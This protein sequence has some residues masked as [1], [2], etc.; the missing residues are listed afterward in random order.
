MATLR[1]RAGRHVRRSG[2]AKAIMRPPRAAAI[3]VIQMSPLRSSALGRRSEQSDR[4]R[5]T[6]CDQP[7]QATRAAAFTREQES[8][9]DADQC[10]LAE[11]PT[12]GRLLLA[13]AE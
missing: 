5:V 3:G 8:G 6:S 4:R 10:C 12:R 1:K 11:R 13:V 7:R 9:V 2:V